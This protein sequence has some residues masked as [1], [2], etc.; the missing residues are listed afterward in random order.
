MLFI[1]RQLRRLELRK[2]SGQYFLYAVGEVVLIVVGILIALQI[3]N[4]NEGRRDQQRVRGHLKEL[5]SELVFNLEEKA[6]IMESPDYDPADYEGKDYDGPPSGGDRGRRPPQGDR[7]RDGRGGNRRRGA[8][9]SA[10][11]SRSRR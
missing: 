4:W 7:R 6:V 2:R 5:R 9:G 1:F 8:R 3:D 11:P 10:G